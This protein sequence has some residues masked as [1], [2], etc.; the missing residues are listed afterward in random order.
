MDV[1]GHEKKYVREPNE[2]IMAEFDGVEQGGGEFGMDQLIQASVL[3][4]NRNKINFFL[5]V[6]PK[7][8]LVRQ[9]MTDGKCQWHKDG[10]AVVSVKPVPPLS[11]PGRLGAASLPPHSSQSRP[12]LAPDASARHPCR[13]TRA[14]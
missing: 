10:P 11:R 4:V 12:C 6:N 5:R 8:H 3:A 14:V 9:R 7:R 1:I 2:S 13:R